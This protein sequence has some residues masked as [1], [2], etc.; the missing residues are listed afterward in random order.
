MNKIKQ[1]S[2][3]SKYIKEWKDVEQGKLENNLRLEMKDPENE[4]E[5]EEICYD[6]NDDDF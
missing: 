1:S 5:F 4:F 6:S 2:L 3:F